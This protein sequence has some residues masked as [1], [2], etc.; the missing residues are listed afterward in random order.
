M[1]GY[2]MRR[3]VLKPLAL[4]LVTL[5]ALSAPLTAFAAETGDEDVVSF[6]ASVES[7]THRMLWFSVLLDSRY[8][9]A[10]AQAFAF[11]LTGSEGT[12]ADESMGLAEFTAPA[13]N[14]GRGF[15]V[16]F[17]FQPGSA[18]VLDKD[19]TYTLTV[20]AGVFSDTDGGQNGA[21]SVEFAASEFIEER[22]GFFGFLDYI[23]NTP[24]LRVLFWPLIAIV[25]LIYSISVYLA[26]R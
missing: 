12:V 18:P 17:R 13:D 7:Y 19:G 22:T 9:S 11:T 16:F 15:E 5:M 14:G 3:V 8:V 26:M 6:Y 23:Y 20:P 1:K 21:L 4:L 2:I 10:D 25:E 24:V